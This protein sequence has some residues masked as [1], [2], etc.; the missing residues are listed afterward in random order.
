MSVDINNVDPTRILVGIPY[1]NTVFH[2]I[3][4]NDGAKLTL[5]S[6]ADNGNGVGFGK[7]VAWLGSDQAA[8]LA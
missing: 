8:I 4:S 3:V 6:Q 1:L 2:F 5:S 7:G